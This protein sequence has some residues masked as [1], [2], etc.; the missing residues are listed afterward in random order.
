MRARVKPDSRKSM[1]I[2]AASRGQRALQSVN[3][4]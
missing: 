3:L 1:R 2:E 4:A